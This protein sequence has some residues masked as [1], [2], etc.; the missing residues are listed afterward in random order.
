[1]IPNSDITKLHSA[2]DVCAVAATA[3]AELEEQAV[4]AAINNNANMGNYSISWNKPLSDKMINKLL[5]E[6]YQ[7][8]NKKSPDGIELKDMYIINAH[9]E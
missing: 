5:S 9:G 3:I 4:A 2:A 1:M 7:V 8:V 6:G